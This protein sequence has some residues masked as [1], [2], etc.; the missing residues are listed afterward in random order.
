[1][2]YAIHTYLVLEAKGER[3]DVDVG[4]GVESLSGHVRERRGPEDAGVV[5]GYVKRSERLNR[6]VHHPLAV[7]FL[8]RATFVH[9]RTK[10]VNM[11]RK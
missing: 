11:E 6:G 2:G 7:G 1:M 3:L 10:R 9:P 5:E 8:K 4:E